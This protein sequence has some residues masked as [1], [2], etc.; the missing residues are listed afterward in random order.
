MSTGRH[1]EGQ[2]T[3][4]YLA[5]R[6][7]SERVVVLLPY[8]R[9]IAW[10]S[11]QVLFGSEAMRRGQDRRFCR[12]SVSTTVESGPLMQPTTCTCAQKGKSFHGMYTQPARPKGAT[13][14]PPG[15]SATA[16]PAR[17]C[18]QEPTRGQSAPERGSTPA[19]PCGLGTKARHP[20][21]PSLTEHLHSRSK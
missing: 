9:R 6:V 4:P 5:S 10:M 2:R 1:Q 17:S 14:A 18:R 11:P 12:S 8:G 19:D 21:Y 3:A 16:N 15:T 20:R 13:N 7:L